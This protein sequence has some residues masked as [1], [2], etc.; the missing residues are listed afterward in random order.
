MHDAGCDAVVLTTEP[1]VR[2]FSGFFTQFWQSP[3]RPWFLIIPSA[4]KPVAVIPEIGSAGMA[5]TWIEDIRTWSSPRPEDDGISLL[6]EAVDELP[7]RFGKVG[8]TLGAETM[9][10][11][12][13]R[14]FEHFRN[15]LSGREVIDVGAIL[16]QQ[17]MVKST[18]EIEKTRYICGIASEA[19][20]NVEN[21]ARAGMSEREVCKQ[22]QLDLLSSGAD[23]AGYMV[24]GSGKGGYDSII[25]GP[26]NR[27]L[28]T[29]D[30]LIIDTGS[31]WDGYFCDFDRNWGFETA[32]DAS[33]RAYEVVWKATEA[34]FM[35]ARPGATTS[36][37]WRAMNEVMVDG[38]SLGNEV[39][40][41][42]HGLG[43]ELTERPS[44]T[45]DDGT[46]LKAGMILTLEPGM[47]FAAGKQMVHE[48][49]IVITDDGA[50]WLTQRAAPEMPVLKN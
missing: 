33:L 38:G 5:D 27:Q 23:T 22:M 44:N 4:G 19:F 7:R 35:A 17:R 39:G 18:L 29:G 10:R 42:G 45:S 16:H 3:T 14:N 24:A 28:A 21:Y 30:I 9:L 6:V 37:V 48:E 31:T 47:T 2:Y 50:E 8:M 13:Q 26:T 32:D 36:D 49:N 20:A 12:P 34:G 1:N 41:L 46:P 25:M 15:K 40:R 43:I 11:M